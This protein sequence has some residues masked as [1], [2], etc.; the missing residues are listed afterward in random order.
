MGPG[1]PLHHRQG[2]PGLGP[3]GP[4]EPD[5]S[6]QPHPR[7]LL[8]AERLPKLHKLIHTDPETRAIFERIQR[9]ADETVASDF[10]ADFPA[11]DKDKSEP[12]YLAIAEQLVDVAFCWRVT[13][14][15]RYAG[16]VQRALTMARYPKGGRFS[17][18]DAGGDSA[19][20]STQCTEFL[21]LLYDWLYRDLTPAERKDFASSLDWRIEHFV[22]HFAWK[23]EVQPRQ[24]RS[25][26]SAP[27]SGPASRAAATLAAASLAAASQPS[28]SRPAASQ[29]MVYSGSISTT[30]G[31]HQYEGFWDT[32]PAS[33]A[34]YE[35][36]P[37]ARLCFALGVNYMIGVGSSHG[38]EEGWNEGPGYGNSKFAWLV[39][40]TSY[41]DSVFPAFGIGRNPWLRR[42]GEYFRSVTP[43]GLQHAPWGHGSDKPEYFETGHRKSYRKLAYL[44]GDGRFLANYTWYAGVDPK[45]AADLM[46]PWIECTLPLWRDRPEPVVQEDAVRLFPVAGWVTALS[47]APSDPDTY[48]HGVGMIFACRPVGAYSHAFA[49]DNSFHIFA[50]GQDISHAAGSSDYEP[51]A[52]HTMSHNAIL[53]DGLGQA[54]SRQTIPEFSRII[55]FAQHDDAVYWCGDATMAY[56]HTPARP[57]AWWGRIGEVYSQRDL[58]YLTRVNRHV[59]FV[60]SKY[61]VV[62]DDLTAAQPAQWTWL[63]HVLSADSFDLDKT[64]GSFRYVIGGVPVQ[65]TQLLGSGQLDVQDLEGDDGF[66]NPLT[67]EDYKDQHGA[68]APKRRFVAAHNLW[69]TTKDKHAGWRF[70]SVIYPVA[71]GAAPATIERLD[72][73]TVRVTADGQTDVISF[74]PRTKQP[75][76]ISVDLAAIA[77]A[78][79]HLATAGG[80]AGR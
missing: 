63:Y 75:A 76:T 44:T 68:A 2:C 65:V 26:A 28:A 14:D 6:T 62:L 9:Q 25:S 77:P 40:S 12:G 29:P 22:N 43:V 59:L 69:L 46:R 78:G 35:D 41:L 58:A 19:E 27:A 54:Q 8:T 45:D 34:A 21:A 17:P 38:F 23:Y 48:K 66:K 55:A 51:Y 16:V 1:P 53:V 72:D 42:Q 24:P 52:F 10:W 79:L 37:N 61:F 73:L 7:I 70:L 18:Q 74:D 33:L 50:Y 4:R 5:F 80:T 71:P 15:P 56:P 32:F 20:D 36:S 49:C 30:A 64:T 31:S 60:R 39:N 13:A 3:L 57:G 11:S 47:G 67:G